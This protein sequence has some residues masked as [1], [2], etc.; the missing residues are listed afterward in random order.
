MKTAYQYPGLRRSPRRYA[1]LLKRL[2]AAGMIAWRLNGSPRVG[3]FSVWKKNGRQRLIVDGRLSN[4]MFAEPDKVELPTGSS[5]GA[6]E[7]DEGPPVSL[8][9]VDIKDAFYQLLLP[10]ELIDFFCLE[11]VAAGL[12]GKS[13]LNGVRLG[14][15][16]YFFRTFASAR[17][18][19]HTPS[20]G[21]KKSMSFML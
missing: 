1:S 2:D 9:Q 6:V 11:A 16:V 5:L 7:V 15:N 21:A 3:L 20:G 14:P 12:V 8:G 18:G 13:C 4:A 10:E 19:G 17:W